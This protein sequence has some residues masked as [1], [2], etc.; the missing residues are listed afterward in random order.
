MS[1]FVA[2]EIQVLEEELDISIL[3]AWETGSRA[4]NFSHSESDYDVSVVYMQSEESYI[5]GCD[6]MQGFSLEQLDVGLAED[7]DVDGWDIRRFRELLFGYDP[8]VCEAVFS[9][10]S[11]FVPSEIERISSHLRGRL[12]PIDLFNGYQGAAEGMFL[13]REDEEYKIPK[14]YLFHVVRNVLMARYIEARHEFPP[15]KWDEFLSEASD[16][17]FF[18]VSRGRARELF[19]AKCSSDECWDLIVPPER[20]ELLQFF[21]YELEYENHVPDNTVN[22]SFVNEALEELVVRQ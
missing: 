17:V 16:E 4:Y 20:D 19:D 18:D 3:A 15:L 7:I 10:V 12:N 14:K 9:P 5:L 6:Y 1:S 13:Q 22:Q 2:S 8:M 11:Y 21:S